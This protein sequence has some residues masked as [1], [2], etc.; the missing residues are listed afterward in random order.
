MK[1]PVYLHP[2]QEDDY[3]ELIKLWEAA[4]QIDIRE[5]D[6]RETFAR[7]LKRNPTSNFGAYAGTSLI[8]AVLAGHDGWRG[9]LYHM[10]VH[11]DYR[12]RGIASQL[13]NVAIGNIHHHGISKIHILVKRE[14]L[15]AQ[16]FWEACGFRLR[17][18]LFDFST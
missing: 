14:N 1:Q 6:T 4:G 3:T 8:G 10:A 2:L 16:Q 5:T 11:P 15:I 7:F 12:E 18:G 9:Y 13:V 17:D